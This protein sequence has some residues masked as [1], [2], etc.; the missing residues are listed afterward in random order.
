MIVR[1]VWK[2]PSFL[3][4][5]FW[6]PLKKSVDDLVVYNPPML[7]TTLM[8]RLSEFLYQ[9]LFLRLLQTTNN[10]KTLSPLVFHS[11]VLKL[12]KLQGKKRCR[13]RRFF[14]ISSLWLLNSPV[15][16]PISLG[17]HEM[18]SLLGCPVNTQVIS[19]FRIRRVFRPLALLAARY[20]F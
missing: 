5:R 15:T 17:D 3:P 1:S 7:P 18:N 12:L 9:T 2:S 11:R 16:L 6:E 13:N 10:C 14:R 8:M 19:G 4:F 20:I